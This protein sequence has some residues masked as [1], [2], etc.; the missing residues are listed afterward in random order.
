MVHKQTHQKERNRKKSCYDTRG[1]RVLR[2]LFLAFSVIVI[3]T[4]PCERTTTCVCMRRER[5]ELLLSTICIFMLLTW[6]CAIRQT[7]LIL[8]HRETN[9]CVDDADY[10]KNCSR[11]TLYAHTETTHVLISALG[12][13]FFVFPSSLPVYMLCTNDI[14]IVTLLSILAVITMMMMNN[15]SNANQRLNQGWK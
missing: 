14:N 4:L 7:W 8:I 1:L 2:F 12:V 15:T 10:K 11:F 6:H 5:F 9:V 3:S 13:F